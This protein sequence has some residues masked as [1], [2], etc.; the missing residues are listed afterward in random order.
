M[1]KKLRSKKVKIS[2]SSEVCDFI[3]EK[4]EQDKM[5]ARPLKRLIQK[6]IEDQIVNYYYDKELDKEICFNFI[7]QVDPKIKAESKISYYI[8]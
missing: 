8:E 3:C 4:A 7:L 5:G 6:N 1:R 2:F